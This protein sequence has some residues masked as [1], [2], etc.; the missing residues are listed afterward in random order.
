M[1]SL[2]GEKSRLRGSRPRGAVASA[3]RAKPAASALAA[4]AAKRQSSARTLASAGSSR[5][6]HSSMTA[7]HELQ[8]EPVAGLADVNLDCC[9][10]G[11][12]SRQDG[13]FQSSLV[14]EGGKTLAARIAD[15]RHDAPERLRR[16]IPPAPRRTDPASRRAASAAATPA[17]ALRMRAANARVPHARR[18]GTTRRSNKSPDRAPRGRRARALSRGS[19]CAAVTLS[20]FAVVTAICALEPAGSDGRSSSASRTSPSAPKRANDAAQRARGKND[21]VIAD[22]RK[23]R[24][25]F[26]DL[27]QRRDRAR[28]EIRPVA[29][30]A[31]WATTSP[32]ATQSTR[33][34]SVS[35]GERLSTAAATSD[36]SEASARIK[37]TRR[38]ARATQHIGER[39]AHQR[40]GVVEQRDHRQLSLG[41]HRRPARSEW[42]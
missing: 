20:A 15:E 22:Q 7:L 23:K 27:G 12:E 38:V 5:R 25:A 42:R 1:S 35:T 4:S 30:R 18:L 33:S 13:G 39:P 29:P 40:R 36:W 14:G 8:L 28:Q 9:Q 17:S 3:S 19:H 21:L 24:F 26:A 11:A 37:G 32:V 6:S 2:A 31:D 10:R 34:A 16:T 41:A